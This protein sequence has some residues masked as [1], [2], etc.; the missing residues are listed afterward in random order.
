MSSCCLLPSL[1][2]LISFL[3]TENGVPG[4][5]FYKLLALGKQSEQ[6]I[7]LFG[8]LRNAPAGVDPVEGFGETDMDTIFSKVESF[9]VAEYKRGGVTAQ[10][11]SR[12]DE[13]LRA[14]R[15]NKERATGTRSL[16]EALT[17]LLA[18]RLAS[19]GFHDGS[20][21]H[22]TGRTNRN[23]SPAGAFFA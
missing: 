8:A 16:N 4:P 3:K 10:A 23:Q 14:M 1:Q 7:N 18:V 9:V 21:A 11:K 15:K 6:W 17:A 20:Y 22:A 2:R 19:G 5:Q 13:A 12:I